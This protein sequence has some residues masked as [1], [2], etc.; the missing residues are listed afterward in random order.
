MEQN[1]ARSDLE[2]AL[3]EILTASSDPGPVHR[4]WARVAQSLAEKDVPR[5]LLIVST[6]FDTALER[7]FN[8]QGVPY[9]LIVPV[10]DNVRARRCTV[11]PR[12][13]ARDRS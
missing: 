6:T 13:G 9:D 7:A 8:D 12:T 10:V 4:F 11:G 2:R 3:D 1:V 5:P